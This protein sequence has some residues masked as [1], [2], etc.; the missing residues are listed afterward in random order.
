ML[1]N[2]MKQIVKEL[3]KDRTAGSC[4]K[5]PLATVA[6]S[7]PERKARF[8]TVSL[9][10]V[11]PLYGPTDTKDIDVERD[12]SSPGAFP[13]TRRIHATGHRGP[14]RTLR[15]AAGL[16]TPQETNARSRYPLNGSKT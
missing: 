9:E 1:K 11:K 7:G 8:E 3:D 15:Q 14:L 13:Y 10:A 16:V 12:L 4:E 6:T 5:Q 2:S